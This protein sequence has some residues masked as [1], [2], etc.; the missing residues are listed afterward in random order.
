M[1]QFLLFVGFLWNVSAY[2]Q[3]LPVIDGNFEGETIWGSPVGIDECCDPQVPGTSDVLNAWFVKNADNIYV[4]IKR[5]TT[6]SGTA[7]YSLRLDLDCGT[8]TIDAGITFGWNAIGSN[9]T[10]NMPL[11]LEWGNKSFSLGNAIQGSPTIAAATCQDAGTY[12]EFSVNM[13]TVISKLLEW[14]AINP[15]ACNCGS[16][17]IMD[18]VSLAGGSFSSAEKDVYSSFTLDYSA[19]VN[20]CPVADFTAR[21]TAVCLLNTNVFDAGIS[22]DTYPLDDV[23]TYSW[24]FGDGTSATGKVANKSWSVAGVYPVVLTVKDKF[25]CTSTKTINITVNNILCGPLPVNLLSF[26]AVYNEQ[27]VT[28]HWQSANEENFSHY[29]IERSTDG[30]NF[31]PIA[32]Y[33]GNNNATGS[34]Y[35]YRDKL[36]RENNTGVLFYRLN[37]H[38]TDGSSR[39]SN[40]VV[41]K[42]KDAQKKGLQIIPNPSNGKQMNI[43]MIFPSSGIASIQISDSQGKIVHKQNSMM[44]EGRNVIQCT[45]E[46][47]LKPGIYIL[48]VYSNIQNF[49]EKLIVQ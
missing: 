5:F 36:I 39:Y 19:K 49:V 32:I 10:S 43:A 7:S 48:S 29:E 14:G 46:S 15:C 31:S 34:I 26:S 4:G 21:Q 28:L 23:L 17:K 35:K 40:I 8:P 18:I 13:Q 20:N 38:N 33:F 22:S 1:K 24:T 16:I 44:Q 9:C 45:P 11:T 3:S 42:I 2:S 47:E 37:M 12:A 25:G 30:R 6:G 41:I 27:T